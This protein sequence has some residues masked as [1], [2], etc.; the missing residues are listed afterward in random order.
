LTTVISSTVDRWDADEAAS[1]IELFV[2]RDLQFI[3]INGTIVGAL[4]GL[5]IHAVSQLV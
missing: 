5:A 2:G 1:R 4:A 3:R